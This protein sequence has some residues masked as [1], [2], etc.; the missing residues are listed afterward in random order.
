M[1]VLHLDRT[2]T[3]LA[4]RNLA[5]IVRPDQGV[6]D[7]QL[8]FIRDYAD[9]RPDRTSEILTQL[10]ASAIFLGSVVHLHPDR[11]PRTLE[12]LAAAL[13]LAN[14][15]HMR[16]KHA[17]ACPRP[18]EYSEQVQPMILTPGHG[19]LPSGHATEAFIASTVLWHLLAAPTAHPVYGRRE[20]CEQLMRLSARIAINRTVAGL[21]FP[22]DSVAGALL[23][24]TLGHYFVARCRQL[25][26]YDSWTFDGSLYPTAVPEDF[27]WRVLFSIPP[28]GNPVQISNGTYVPASTSN[29][30]DTTWHSP[31]LAW[32]WN[33][34]KA[35]WS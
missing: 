24:L 10:G 6:F 14:F 34:A 3:A 12:L 33:E 7:S 21:H 26:T 32:L 5:T 25:T 30:F 16:L 17:L 1:H 9:L 29:T 4:Y 28:M 18:I 35:E 8:S 19:S 15:V 23:G 31:L 27:N 13:R 2:G 11:T 20:A 22:V